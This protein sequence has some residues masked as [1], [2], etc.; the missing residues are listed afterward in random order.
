MAYTAL[1]LQKWSKW[2][3]IQIWATSCLHNSHN[4][5]FFYAKF[6]AET[7]IL[8]WDMSHI[9]HPEYSIAV[10]V[11]DRHILLFYEKCHFCHLLP[12]AKLGQYSK[13]QLVLFPLVPFLH[14]VLVWHTWPSTLSLKTVSC[15]TF[16]KV[17]HTEIAFQS[18]G[19][20]C[21]LSRFAMVIMVGKN[22]FC[23]DPF[24]AP[25]SST[26]PPL[27]STQNWQRWSIVLNVPY[28]TIAR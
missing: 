15:P 18:L 12:G 8:L 13:E 5:L 28:L 9:R 19:N 4:E 14:D 26:Y 7:L 23:P 10:S 20:H 6:L 25:T 3:T 1:L 24:Y 2:H 22:I 17:W 21:R 27:I 11:N 16:Y